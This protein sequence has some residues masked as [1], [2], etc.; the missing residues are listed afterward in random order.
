MTPVLVTLGVLRFSH[1]GNRWFPQLSANPFLGIS[2]EEHR[3]TPGSN[4]QDFEVGIKLTT[5]IFKL[6]ANEGI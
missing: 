2:W 1:G 4:I 3:I 6:M 5:V